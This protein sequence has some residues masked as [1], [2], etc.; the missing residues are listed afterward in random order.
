MKRNSMIKYLVILLCLFT[1]TSACAQKARRQ[2]LLMEDSNVIKTVK[3]YQDFSFT[4]TGGRVISGKVFL[5]NDSQFYYLNYFN[6]QKGPVHNINE[7]KGTYVNVYG[8]ESGGNGKATGQRT[9]LSPG[10][11]FL[12]MALTAGYAAPILLI[13]EAILFYKYGQGHSLRR[14][15]YNTTITFKT[16]LNIKIQRIDSSN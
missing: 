7:I 16:K 4:D 5:K 3:D 9:F 15:K 2:M 11:V 14:E 1:S 8:P 13:R 10:S 12:I 6:E